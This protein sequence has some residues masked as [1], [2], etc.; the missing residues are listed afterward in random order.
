MARS[1]SHSFFRPRTAGAGRVMN[2]S[3]KLSD[4]FQSL[5]WGDLALWAGRSNLA[6]GRQQQK[7]GAVDQLAKTGTGGLIAWV[8]AEEL[9]ATH[10]EIENNELFGECTCQGEDGCE[11]AVAVILEYVAHLIKKMDI[12]VAPS[13]DQRYFLL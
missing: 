5:T 7:A 11:H 9:F 8:K 6:D 4:P 12:P 2:S 1:V 3:H 13:N 10:V